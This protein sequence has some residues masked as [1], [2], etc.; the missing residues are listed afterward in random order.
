MSGNPFDEGIQNY[1]A[2]IVIVN[3]DVELRREI[4]CDGTSAEEAAERM[5][6]ALRVVWPDAAILISTPELEGGAK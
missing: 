3:G 2:R 5:E 4:K 6:R 1:R